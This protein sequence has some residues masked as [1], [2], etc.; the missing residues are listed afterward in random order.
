MSNI[1]GLFLIYVEQAAATLFASSCILIRL[2]SPFV[3]EYSQRPV[4]ILRYHQSLFFAL[5]E[6]AAALLAAS[7]AALSLVLVLVFVPNIKK[8]QAQ[9]QQE[10]L[11]DLNKVNQEESNLFD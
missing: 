10:G 11:M 3:L 1:T 7:G 8:Q 4:C 2:Q 6:Q 5:G 9:H